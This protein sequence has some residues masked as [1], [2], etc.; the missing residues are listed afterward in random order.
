MKDRKGKKTHG[1]AKLAVVGRGEVSALRSQLAERGE[2]LRPMLELVE[3]A[4]ASIDELMSETARSFVEQLLVI[5][6]EELA[7]AKHPGRRAGAVRWHG[8]QAGR[9]VLAERKLSVTRPRLRTRGRGGKEVAV[10]L[11]ERLTAEPRLADRMRDILVAGV[12]TRKYARV[13]PRMAGTAGISRS[14]VSR[15]FVK[16]AA[17][18]LE[19][20]MGRRLEGLDVLA[21][22]ID[23]IVV[24]DHHI[25]AAVGVDVRGEKH[26]LS[27]AQGSSE[28]AR[29]AKDLLGGLIE[30]G[31]SPDLARLFVIDGSKALRSAIEELFGDRARIQ[32]CRI[33]KLRNVTERLPKQI[34]RQVRSVLHAAYQLPEKEG[35]A[36]LKQQAAWLKS[37]YPDAA[38]SLLE[39]LEESFTVN[40]L[41]LPPS[42]TRC[43]ASTN[44]IENPNGA[45]RRVT[46]RVT[47]YRDAEMALRWTAAG[48]LE[49]EQSFKRIDG[50]R[51]LWVLAAALGRVVENVDAKQRAA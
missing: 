5:S 51:D 4:R 47:R 15:R 29:V 27:L 36:K 25:L 37:E 26:L 23:G 1:K 28:N 46:R 3:N 49:A 18:S 10:P 48:F 45:V 31:L 43:L 44:V 40:R 41:R 39:G 38:A 14:S 11:Y 22:W 2:L 21:V 20:L 24:E 12:S 13:L 8:T 34:A 6:A 9:I 30:R 50:H 35:M 7:G 19:A 42:L 32:R 16:A 17:R 33:H